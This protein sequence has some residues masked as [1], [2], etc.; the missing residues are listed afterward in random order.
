MNTA[1]AQ[2]WSGWIDEVN[3]QLNTLNASVSSM[4]TAIEPVLRQ[5]SESDIQ[6]EHAATLSLLQTCLADYWELK[7][8]Y[9]P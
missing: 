6:A 2:R 1:M 4:N 3:Q 7:G 5:L 9:K 8:E